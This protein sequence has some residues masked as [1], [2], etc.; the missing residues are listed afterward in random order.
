[1]CHRVSSKMNRGF[2]VLL[3]YAL[4]LSVMFLCRCC[5]M[6]VNTPSGAVKEVMLP[7]VI[8]QKKDAFKRNR[9]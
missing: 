9:T 6:T 8:A 3:V 4:N 2:N 7:L 5:I 1:M